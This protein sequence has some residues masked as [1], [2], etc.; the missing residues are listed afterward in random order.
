MLYLIE[1][2]VDNYSYIW[3]LLKEHSVEINKLS[4]ALELTYKAIKK[5]RKYYEK[6]RKINSSNLESKKYFA[7]FLSKY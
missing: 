3:K 1:K 6:N 2:A 7:I 5:C 4:V